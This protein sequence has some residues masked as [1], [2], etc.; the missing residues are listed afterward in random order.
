MLGQAERAGTLHPREEKA[1][2]GYKY[3][4]KYVKGRC[5]KE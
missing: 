5:K 4:S 2:M 1:Q 3:I